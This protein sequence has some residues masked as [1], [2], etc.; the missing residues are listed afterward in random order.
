MGSKNEVIPPDWE[1]LFNNQTLRRVHS[2]DGHTYFLVCVGLPEHVSSHLS[3]GLLEEMLWAI[4]ARP[5]YHAVIHPLYLS[6][7]PEFPLTVHA[8]DGK[9]LH[10][11]LYSGYI[12]LVRPDVVLHEEDAPIE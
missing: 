2:A 4:F 11:V 10:K 1:K 5:H 9:V 6:T 8:A 3:A 12:A 7:C